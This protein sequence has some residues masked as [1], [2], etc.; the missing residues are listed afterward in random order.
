MHGVQPAVEYKLIKIIS[1]VL[2]QHKIV[3]KQPDWNPDV[4]LDP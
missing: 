4:D 3:R 1:D 2:V